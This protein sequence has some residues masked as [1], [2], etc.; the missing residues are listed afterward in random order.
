MAEAEM[1][2][3]PAETEETQAPLF[4]F[5]LAGATLLV[6]ASEVESVTA[7]E[8]P[9]PLPR[10]PPHVL[11][12]VNHDQQA[13]VVVDLARF[14]G[15][16]PTVAQ[17]PG[18]A[19]RSRMLVVQSGGYRVGIPVDAAVGVVVVSARDRH[20]PGAATGGRVAEF[21]RAECEVAGSPAGWLDMPRLLEAARA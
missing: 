15:L 11:G 7:C 3:P 9:M 1:D 6:A 2:V 14:L 16:P 18:G 19:P 5:R 12:L 17:G 21:L 13:L 20:A 8:P 4:L 10:V